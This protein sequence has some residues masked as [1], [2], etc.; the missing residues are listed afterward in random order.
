MFFED[1]LTLSADDAEDALLTLD[2][3]CPCVDGFACGDDEDVECAFG[4]A[5]DEMPFELYPVSNGGC[6][7][8]SRKR[9][10]M[11]SNIAKSDGDDDADA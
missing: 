3:S 2:D 1:V 6:F 7:K 11:R 8:L 9:N 4:G 10:E 5:S